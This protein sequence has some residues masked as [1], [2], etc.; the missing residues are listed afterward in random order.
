MVCVWSFVYADD[1]ITSPSPSPHTAV[2]NKPRL[3]L[4]PQPEHTTAE[5]C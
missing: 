4:N 5:T 2:Y 1:H 3:E